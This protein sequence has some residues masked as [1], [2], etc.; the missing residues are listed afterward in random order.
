MLSCGALSSLTLSSSST[1]RKQRP[2]EVVTYCENVSSRSLG[3]GL[4][5]WTRFWSQSCG[6][7]HLLLR[8][9]DLTSAE[10]LPLLRDSAVP[11]PSFLPPSLLYHS[12][13][14]LRLISTL[15]VGASISK[16]VHVRVWVKW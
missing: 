13:L 7:A 12:H 10:V 16:V 11:L 6:Q 14:G 15:T 2:P 9:W 5:Q 8:A 3:G 1:S 4:A